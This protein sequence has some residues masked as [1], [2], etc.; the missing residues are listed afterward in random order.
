MTPP[1]RQ[2]SLRFWGVRGSIPCPGPGTVRYG[3]NTP[4]VS[5]ASEDQ[6]LLVL[7]AGTGI[8]ALGNALQDAGA[9][10]VD[11]LLS[12]VHWD[13][14]QGLGFFLPLYDP[15]TRIRITGPHQDPG[16]RTVL[17]RLSAWEN[18]P[19]PPSR[20][21]GVA[22]VKEIGAGAFSIGGWTVGAF[23]LCHPG[24][25]LGYRL[26]RPGIPPVAYLP[27]NELAGKVHGVTDGWRDA[28]V[29]FLRG[30]ETLIHD[31]T[32]TEEQRE[33]Y[34]GWGHSSST[35]AVRLAGDAGCRRLVLFHHNPDHD[36][37]A[38]D[39]LLDGTRAEAAGLAPGLEVEAAIEGSTLALGTERD[40]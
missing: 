34:A 1:P 37:D 30:V 14:I 3:G 22:D 36:D 20:W 40:M 29:D 5:I 11:L 32:W 8:R 15:A 4:C 24:H 26:E 12:H 33:R 23:R 16:L 31:A 28:L 9:A 35:E 25:T 19:I 38:V 10:T 17:E 27:D 6:S 39:A 7:D 18:F 21:E 13:H 2:A